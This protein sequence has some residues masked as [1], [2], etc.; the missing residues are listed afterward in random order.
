MLVEVCEVSA[1]ECEDEGEDEGEGVGDGNGDGES[2]M[3]VLHQFADIDDGFDVPV[4]A[5]KSTHM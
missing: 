3:K 2:V 4:K 5:A 1:P